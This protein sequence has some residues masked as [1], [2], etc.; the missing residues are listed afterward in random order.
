MTADIAVTPERPNT[1]PE[2]PNAFTGKS[3]AS[4]PA[5]FAGALSAAAATLLLMALGS[6]L[7]LASISPWSNHGVSATTFAVA[8][9]P[10][11]SA[12]T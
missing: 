1:F 5:I 2:S 12:G 4:W 8:G 7:G 11:P 9:A 6:G 10:A 3:A